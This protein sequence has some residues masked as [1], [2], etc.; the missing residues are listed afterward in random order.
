MYC[1]LEDLASSSSHSVLP[2]SGSQRASQQ[3]RLYRPLKTLARCHYVNSPV[4][5]RCVAS[6]C[7]QNLKAAEIVELGRGRCRRKPAKRAETCRGG[8]QNFLPALSPGHYGESREQCVDNKYC[9]RI[10]RARRPQ[11]QKGRRKRQ[12]IRC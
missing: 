2:S 12:G 7:L 5:R 11:G 1:F 4:R 3:R 6:P 10:G 8:L 9:W